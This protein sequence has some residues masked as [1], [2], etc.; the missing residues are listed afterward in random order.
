MFKN[1]KL[2]A[3]I[4]TGFAALIAIALLLGGMATLIMN[5]VKSISLRLS[6]QN[7]PEV[8]VATN[9]ERS[10]LNTMY[11]ARGYVFTEE[12]TYLEKA[13]KDLDEVKKYLAD[14]KSHANKYDLAALRE[15]AGKAETNALEYE[16]L[17]NDTVVATDAMGKE[18]AASLEAADRYMKIC[19]DFLSSQ[20]NALDADI[21]TALGT[22]SSDA[23]SSQAT[24]TEQKLQ[25][26][27]QKVSLCNDVIDLGNAIRLGTWQS[28]ATRDPK[29]FQDTEKKFV[30]VN[31]KLDELKTITKL[32]LN[33]KQIEECR[34]AGKEYLG[35][36]ERFLTNWLARE[37]LNKKRGVAADAVL[38]AAQATSELGL[39]DTTDAAGKA[40][41]SLSTAS[42][43]M[44]IGLIAAVMIGVLL[45][46]FITRGITG[47]LGRVIEGMTRGSEQVSS[48][49]GQVAQSSQSMAEGASEQASSLEEV[50]S[51]LEEMASMT[52]Q[53]ADNA[54]DANGKADLARQAAMKGRDAM[55]RM[56][57]AIGEIKTSSD[58]TAKI[59]KTIDE[60]AFQTNLLALNAAVEAARAGDAGK[61][62]AVV[63]E[64]VRNLA[65]R[66]AEAAKNTASLIEESQKN[67]DNGVAVSGEVEHILKQIADGAQQVTQLVG[68]V[69]SA[70]Q[71]QAQGI[72]QV[73]TAVAQM[74]KVTQSNAANAEESASASEELSAQARE[75]SEMVG[76]LVAIV[77]GGGNSGGT[78]DNSHH[79]ASAK[80]AGESARHAP[81][82]Y[83]TAQGNGGSANGR[84]TLHLQSA[85]AD[86][87]QS[88]EQVIPLDSDEFN[89]F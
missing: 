55:V 12:K 63:A 89:E 59:L 52:K 4:G 41:G 79:A 65:Q 61:G 85:K 28:I 31:K 75:L 87:R 82:S 29:L 38:Q 19:Y 84:K 74:D 37:D 58:K 43:T 42:T 8:A 83:K 10:S 77:G 25:E 24:M 66:S 7:V 22:K 68:Q 86:R 70:T 14:A 81:P 48:A 23:A 71:E 64:E 33:L 20:S 76:V 44:I 67:A 56:S 72:E 57:A 45:A 1:M 32:E 17:L 30:E 49:S 40:S 18:K 73:N 9:V 11:Q 26:R 3:K 36:M 51:S 2:S 50:S 16:K 47:P 21:K 35:C 27:V 5:N 80:H 6:N 13:R 46:I 60:I 34:A 54:K 15:N 53:N 78:A 39:K 69:A 62:F 88:P